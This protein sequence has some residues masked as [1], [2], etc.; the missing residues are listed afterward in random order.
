MKPSVYLE[1][2][3]ISYLAAWPSR[4]LVLAGH[5]QLTRDWWET[6]RGE[7]DLCISEAVVQEL[8][9]GDPD[10]ATRRLA[11][12]DGI[13]LIFVTPENLALAVEMARRSGLPAKA[14]IDALH[15]TLAAAH[16]IDFLMT[17]NCKHIAGAGFRPRIESAC[18]AIGLHPP[19]IATP[20]DM[21]EL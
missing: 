19:V 6:R 13:R 5:Q 21:M 2:T 8:Q 1:T 20:M 14:G 4:D 18:R 3:I 7:Y 15:V 11:L 10:A 9:D 16:K 12:V 17:W